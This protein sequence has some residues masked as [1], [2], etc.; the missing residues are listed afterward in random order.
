M[1]VAI[2]SGNKK[3]ENSDPVINTGHVRASAIPTPPVAKIPRLLHSTDV[4]TNRGNLPFSA[5]G[6]FPPPRRVASNAVVDKSTSRVVLHDTDL[7]AKTD[8]S[9]SCKKSDNPVKSKR[10]ADNLSVIA[11]E[12]GRS[13]DDLSVGNVKSNRSADEL[14]VGSSFESNIIKEN[15]SVLSANE[16]AKD[17]SV[18]V[19]NADESGDAEASCN[20]SPALCESS[21][22]NKKYI[23]WC[24]KI[25]VNGTDICDAE[26]KSSMP[27]NVQSWN[28]YV[29]IK[30]AYFSV[31]HFLILLFARF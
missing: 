19:T 17:F 4:S 23:V 5:T 12:S 2:Y 22:L 18:L 1:F 31:F 28:M 30:S 11:V 16:S 13:V 14:S 21:E 9:L 26:I 24:G 20:V 8:T 7:R 10:A 29:Y 6:Y 15:Q 3:T 25:A 27:L